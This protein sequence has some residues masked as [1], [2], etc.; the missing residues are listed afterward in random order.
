MIIDRGS[1]SFEG[2]SDLNNGNP[3]LHAL[4]FPH[5]G[6]RRRKTVG[7]HG[8]SSGSMYTSNL[9]YTLE[10]QHNYGT[11]PF[12]VDFSLEH[13]DFRYRNC[14]KMGQLSWISLR[15]GWNWSMAG[16][17]SKNDGFSHRKVTYKSMVHGWKSMPWS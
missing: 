9:G 4:G 1:H 13:G 14:S 7:R 12:I 10:N 5:R 15:P 17:S 16:E 8:S 6:K 11:W 2:K 3:Q